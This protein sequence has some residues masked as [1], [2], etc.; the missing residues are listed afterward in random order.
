M[1]FLVIVL[2]AAVLHLLPTIVLFADC[3]SS[4]V[5]QKK[6]QQQH[7]DNLQDN[8]NILNDEFRKHYALIDNIRN[9]KCPDQLQKYYCLNE[10]R[11]FNYKIGKSNSY[12]CECKDEF[13]GERCEY[14]YVLKQIRIN[15]D[16]FTDYQL[17]RKSVSGV[18]KTADLSFAPLL[19]AVTAIIF[20]IFLIKKKIIQNCKNHTSVSGG[21]GRRRTFQLGLD[22]EATHQCRYNCSWRRRRKSRTSR[23]SLFV[24]L[25]FL[26][27]LFVKSSPDFCYLFLVYLVVARPSQFCLGNKWFHF[28]FLFFLYGLVMVRTAY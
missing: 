24:I 15:N 20:I 7:V 18:M 28:Q 11:C 1:K 22:N 23:G 26:L 25:S 6:Y 17:I 19:V 8:N 14:K 12:A 13:H 2:L 5:L 9:S 16:T 27:Q 3:C 10:G 21:P 4:K